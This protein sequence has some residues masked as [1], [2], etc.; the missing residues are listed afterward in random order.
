MA[1]KKNTKK[2]RSIKKKVPTKTRSQRSKPAL[3]FSKVKP[4]AIK[5][6]ERMKA[7]KKLTQPA[8]S[9]DGSF[10]KEASHHQSVPDNRLPHAYGDN[11]LVLLVR[12]PWWLYAYWE[13][14]PERMR[15]TSQDAQK[16]DQPYRTV[17]RVYD[18]TGLAGTKANSYFDI[19]LNFYTDNWYI[20]VGQPNREWVAEIGLRLEDGTFLPIVR[21]NRVRTPAFGLSDVL[22]EEWMMPDELYYQIIGYSVSNEQAG[23][24]MDV[25]KLL[26]R[27]LRKAVSSE[28]RQPNVKV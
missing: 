20:D 19:E 22:D 15:R 25:R 28:T 7:S 18:V 14:T 8:L 23:S 4:R 3:R 17:L 27:Y 5:K 2:N 12:D 1:A 10:E 26:E 6:T 13:I 16:K 21:S 9:V 11:R 24:S